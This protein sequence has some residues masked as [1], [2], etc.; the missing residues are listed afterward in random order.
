[1]IATAVIVCSDTECHR[2]L[3]AAV[4]QIIPVADAPPE[5][6]DW[7]LITETD[8]PADR[9]PPHPPSHMLVLGETLT[10][11]FH[12]NTLLARLRSMAAPPPLA[13]LPGS[14]LLLDVPARVLRNAD[15]GA[16]VALT[17]KETRLLE[18]LA[19][20]EGAPVEKDR[21]LAEVWAYPPEVTTRTPETHF[22]R[23]RAKLRRFSPPLTV[24]LDEGGYRLR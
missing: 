4:A 12:L 18:V 23:L 3:K 16:S 24:E 1:M 13:I 8:A 2:T 19:R 14:A 22:S 9:V 20:A 15:T 5:Q 11:P 7:L 17:E 10:L 21:L 6:G